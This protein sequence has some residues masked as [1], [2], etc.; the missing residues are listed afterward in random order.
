M[1]NSLG[2]QFTIVAKQRACGLFIAWQSTGDGAHKAV[3]VLFDTALIVL[4][5]RSTPGFINQTTQRRRGST[6]LLCQPF[7]MTG[8]EGHFAGYYAE[9]G[10]T[11]R[12]LSCRFA[13]KLSDIATRLRPNVSCW[14]RVIHL[15]TGGI[16]KH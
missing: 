3:A 14:P 4:L 11:N 2:K 6:T 15:G 5:D 16:I 7:P 10:P 8:Q 9:L 13:V 12:G 1:R